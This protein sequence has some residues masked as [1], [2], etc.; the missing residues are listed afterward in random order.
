MRWI[1]LA[2]AL[3][4]PAMAQTVHTAF[5]GRGVTDPSPHQIVRT[6]GDVLYAVAPSC[7]NGFPNCGP[8][9]LRVYAAT[10]PGLP[11]HFTELDAAHAPHGN[12][13][14]SAVAVDGSDV[15][16]IVWIDRDG[17]GHV[18]YGTFDTHQNAW[19]SRQVLRVTHWTD[20]TQ[21]QE[22]AVIALDAAGNPHVLFS[23]K[24]T[25]PSDPV[26]L[27]YAT[28]SGGTWSTPVLID[29]QAVPVPP[30]LT[31][32]PAIAFGPDGTLLAAWL[33]GSCTVI[34]DGTCY[35]PDA[36][37]YTRLRS[38]GGTWQNTV[39]L[40]DQSFT[41]I[42]NGPSVMVT[43]DGVRHITFLSATV[44][45]EDEIRYWYDA[46][47]GWQGDQQPADQVTHDP[48]LGPDGQGGLYIYGHGAPPPPD[49]AGRGMNK[50][51]F[52]KP[53]GAT[54]WGPW[55]L[56]VA[57]PID[58]ASSTRWSQF[59]YQFPSEND[60]TYWFYT[61]PYEISVATH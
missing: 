25:A 21:G 22:G 10:T 37:I 23:A 58:D 40:P 46:G 4:R 41:T 28:A 49:Y 24:P 53:A 36:T 33:Q 5:I 12:I 38:P 57:G 59:F 6:S 3:S 50:Y 13:G 47:A 27:Y 51:V 30:R 7:N 35:T 48:V 56:L 39:A 16:H 55:T 14:S 26:R 61:T 52:H 9:R 1:L 42:D 11:R 54:A 18:T 17:P 15:L 60:V 2:L 31:E 44:N 20:F 32:H 19:T 34:R 8:G 45:H 29:A 43:A